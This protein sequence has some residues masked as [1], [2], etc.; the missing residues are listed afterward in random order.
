MKRDFNICIER[1][2]D[3]FYVA[4]VPELPGCYTQAKSLDK[5]L[6]RIKEAI[7]VYIEDEEALGDPNEFI[8]M[9]RVAV[10]V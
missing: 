3:G 4:S 5:L 8:G 9:Q 1:D 6:S 10:E 2:A 7:T